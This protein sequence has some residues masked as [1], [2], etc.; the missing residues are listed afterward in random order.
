MQE[1]IKKANDRG[2]ALSLFVAYFIDM[3]RNE[4]IQEFMCSVC[5]LGMQ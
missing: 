2:C 4:R 5:S 1:M 3:Q